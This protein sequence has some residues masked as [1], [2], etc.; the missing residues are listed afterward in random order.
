[1]ASSCRRAGAYLREALRPV[2]HVLHHQF[3]Q[4]AIADSTII[5]DVQKIPKAFNFVILG[6][7]MEDEPTSRWK[8]KVI[9]IPP[10][11]TPLHIPPHDF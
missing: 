8:S 9:S 6:S 3:Q 2:S 4:G 5:L 1:M 7:T 10:I 11:Q